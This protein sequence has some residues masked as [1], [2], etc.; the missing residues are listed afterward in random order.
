P[1]WRRSTPGRAEGTGL[2]LHICDQIVRAH[3]GRL[4]VAS[5]REAGTTFSVHIPIAAKGMA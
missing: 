4:S 3:G 5:T 2:G 1:F